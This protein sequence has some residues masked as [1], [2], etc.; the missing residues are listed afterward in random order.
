MTS[1]YGVIDRLKFSSNKTKMIS[2]FGFVLCGS[3]GN[4]WWIFTWLRHSVDRTQAVLFSKGNTGDHC[5]FSALRCP[6]FLQSRRRLFDLVCENKVWRWNTS[7]RVVGYSRDVWLADLFS[8]KREFRKLFIFEIRDLWRFCVT[9][10]EL[11]LLTDVRDPL[12][13]IFS[14]PW[15]VWETSCTTLYAVVGRSLFKC[16]TG[17]FLPLK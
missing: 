11:E 8:A 9:R 5:L 6:Y 7:K 15:T 13:S 16:S 12:C 1:R 3:V 14:C 4:I 2:V 17:E 10:E